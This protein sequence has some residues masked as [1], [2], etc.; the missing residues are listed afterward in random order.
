MKKLIFVL[1]LLGMSALVFADNSP[2]AW[3]NSAKRSIANASG[4][5]SRHQAT[6]DLL[7]VTT[8]DLEKKIEYDRLWS[9]FYQASNE[10]STREYHEK[11]ATDI[12]DRKKAHEATLAGKAELDRAFAELKR[13]VEGL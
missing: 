11:M 7:Q 1:M 2:G 5:V 12:P 9:R 13:F 6:I 4:T 3:T 8:D 10:L